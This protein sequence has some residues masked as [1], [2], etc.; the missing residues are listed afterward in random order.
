MVDHEK[1]SPSQLDQALQYQRERREKK[2]G[3]ILKEEKIISEE[4][5]QESLQ[6]QKEKAKLLGEIL[7][8]AGYVTPEQLEYALNIQR[9]NR[10]KKLGQILV[11]LKYVTP[12]DICI[13]LATQLHF[14][15][16]DL[17]QVKIPPE[18]AT[19]LPER[20]VRECGV[21]PIE[22]KGDDTL[23]VAASTPQDPDIWREIRKST[24]L[25]VELVVA[26]EG[27]I[28]EAIN[29]HFPPRNN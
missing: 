6:R 2:I 22:Q 23:V 10:E 24:A 17:S 25:K 27:Y 16:V 5:L 9:E 1:I 28:D 14:P 15:W 29:Y 19:S 13:A 3:T 12:T 20:I 7:I 8:E 21:I 26:Y 18:I 4:Q 11:E